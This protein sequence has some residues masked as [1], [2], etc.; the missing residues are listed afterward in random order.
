MNHSKQKV[1]VLGTFHMHEQEG[2]QTKKRQEEIQEVVSVLEKF[3]PTKIAVE[4]VVE[5]SESYHDEYRQYREGHFALRMNEIYQV[6]FR[7][8]ADLN[9]E[10][11][12]AID[13]MGKADMDYDEMEKWATENQPELLTQ[14]FDGFEFP[15]LSPNKSVL[16]YYKELNDPSLVNDLHKLYVNMARIGEFGHYVG[17]DW[18][19]WWY[20]R[21]LI[22]FANLCRLMER[23]EE[24]ILF[25]VGASHT[26]IVT[27][28]LEESGQCEVVPAMNYL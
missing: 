1:L 17:L 20:K 12:Y 8:A 27:K 14:L 23:D 28:F 24:R 9:H 6:G 2:L 22:L 13:W 15:S 11:I 21:N 26:S 5:D 7:L 4:A 16:D 3:H 18:L 19:S 25:I 10:Q